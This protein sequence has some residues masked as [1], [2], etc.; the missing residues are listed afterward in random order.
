MVGFL[1]ERAKFAGNRSEYIRH[2]ILQDMFG[3]QKGRSDFAVVKEHEHRVKTISSEHR[4]LHMEMQNELK[5][6]LKKV[7]DNGS[8]SR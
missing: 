2:L 3:G 7:M 1:N 6:K 4:S 5:T 8:E